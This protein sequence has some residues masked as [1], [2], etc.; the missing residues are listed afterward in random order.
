M[1][2]YRFSLILDLK[3]RPKKL[4]LFINPFCGKKNAVQIFEKYTKPLFKLADINVTVIVTQHEEEIRDCISSLHLYIYD[5][6]ACAGGDGTFSEVF[7]G[8]ILRTCREQH[9]NIN[10]INAVLPVPQLPVGIIPAG[11]TNT[12][13]Y[14]LHG[15]ADIQTAVLKIIYGNSLGLDLVSVY[16]EQHLLR[17]YG[18]ALS[19][20]FLGDVILESEKYRW[21]GPKRYEYSG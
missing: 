8:L 10:D 4:L 20:G 14:C 9:V 15:T 19:Y 1:C 17:L 2:K 11:S 21:M 16:N 18:S 3:H 6:V 12:I 7:N 5:A 13:A